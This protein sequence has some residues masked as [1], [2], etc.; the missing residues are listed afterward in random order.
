MLKTY[1]NLAK[2]ILSL[3]L[4][5]NSLVSLI[6]AGNILAGYYASRPWWQPYSPYLMSGLLF[7]IA[8]LTAL[9][10]IVPSKMV[11][12]VHIRRLL[13]HH[14]V[15]GFLIMIGSTLLIVSF[16]PNSLTTLF[17]PTFTGES[18]SLQ[19]LILYMELFF[20]YGGLT[21]LLDD[22]Q[23]ISLRVSR[24]LNRFKKRTHKSGKILQFV[25]LCCSLITIYI[26][27]AVFLWSIEKY[28][29]I[30]QYPLWFLS[31]AILILSLLIN[32]VWGSNV[33][34]KMLSRK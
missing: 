21:L 30:S 18:L 6:S 28:H 31:H 27:L 11:G 9:L 13:F 19:S 17:T 5:F 24:I 32:G 15:Y 7:W 3:T 22:L 12:R 16:I 33:T 29:W 25:H 34:K 23:D 1:A 14:Y 10:N 26:S 8:I 4:I 2:K 20:L